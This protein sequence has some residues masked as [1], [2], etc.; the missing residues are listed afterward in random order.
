LPS[1][2]ST[3]LENWPGPIN[4]A[5]PVRA[6]YH[7]AVKQV[8]VSLDFHLEQFY[9]RKE[10]SFHYFDKLDELITICQRFPIDLIIIGGKHDLLREIE[11]VRAIKR[12][13][14]LSIIP[15]I[16]YHPNPSDNV[17]IAAYENGAEDFIFGEWI[18]QLEKVRIQRVIERS[19]R[20]LSVNSST[21]LPGMN[22]IQHEITK[23]LEMRA[24]FA[25][26]YA[27][28]DN[29]KAYNDYYGYVSGD[30]VIKLT[31][32]IVK[33]VVFDV[34]RGG[35]VGH[36]AG[37]DFIFI[38]SIDL[39]K[40]IC[41]AIIKT[42]DALIQYRYEPEDRQRGSITTTNR[43]GEIEEFPL[44]TISI[45]VLPNSN[46]E[47]EHAGEMSRML[48]DL[49]TATKR[50]PGSNYLIERRRKY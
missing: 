11:M 42:F 33:D 30:K 3:I 29:F 25:V 13:I 15:T 21:R 28:L 27:D 18:D 35:F 5:E 12:N 44:L 40:K 36:I 9:R 38:I 6:A 14:F 16:L 41:S 22:M 32:R 31:A 39:V 34:C 17:A 26:C 50:M 1:T 2:K 37:D 49:K 43:R 4:L 48:A 23:L 46:G 7:F 47:F 8:G 19:R 45:A 10:V 24:D 20:D